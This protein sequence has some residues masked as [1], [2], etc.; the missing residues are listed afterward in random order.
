MLDLKLD[1]EGVPPKPAATLVLVRD[2]ARG[3][4]VF[5][6]ERNKKSR[7]LGGAVV[8]PGGRVDASDAD[9]AWA[10]LVRDVDLEAL[11]ARAPSADAAAFASDV[12][13]LRALL[14]ASCRETLEEAAMLPVAGGTVVQDDLFALRERLKADPGAVRAFLG[15][16]GLE[17]A[18][19]ALVPFARWIT[20][21]AEARRFDARF[22][23]AIAPE[24]QTGAH[25][26]YETMASFW[27]TPADVL[28]RFE[29]GEVQLAPPTHRTLE[30]FTTCASAA[31]VLELA[32]A[33]TLLPICP[34]LVKQTDAQGETLALTLPGDPEHDIREARTPGLSRYV[35]RGERWL[36]ENAP[37]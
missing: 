10:P 22:F 12:T 28:R 21:Q 36:P 19:S 37:R 1:R 20:P 13:E 27:A 26:E 17:L 15:A 8:F 9:P 16:R 2:G 25:D 31:A 18:T 3:V 33:S 14:V 24:G 32:R 7:F 11:R 5:C 29:A 30:L 4:E 34:R 6:V 23:V 35:L